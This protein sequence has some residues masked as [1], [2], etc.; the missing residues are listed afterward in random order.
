MVYGLQFTLGAFGAVLLF[1]IGKRL[2]DARVGLL[3][4]AGFALYSTEIIYEGI[5]LRAAFITFLG[6][7]SF[8]MLIHLRD[9]SS[10]LMLIGCALVLSLFF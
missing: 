2:F 5:I 6:I 9:S 7:L 4:F 3:A 10:P 1:L 8:Y